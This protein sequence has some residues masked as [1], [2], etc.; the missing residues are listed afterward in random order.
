M[1]KRRSQFADKIFMTNTTTPALLG[2]LNSMDHKYYVLQRQQYMQ[3][4]NG[5]F[6][7]EVVIT[8]HWFYI[9]TKFQRLRSCSRSS[10]IRSE[11]CDIV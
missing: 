10:A 9:L 2:T 6:E 3:I 4:E 8:R 5:K 1:E 11:K 7:P